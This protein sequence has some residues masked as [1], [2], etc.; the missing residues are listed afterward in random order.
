MRERRNILVTRIPPDTDDDVAGR[1]P[2][3]MRNALNTRQDAR[4]E[5]THLRAVTDSALEFE[6]V[7]FVTTP[8]EAAAVAVQEAV[9]LESRRAFSA[10][11]VRLISQAAA[12]RAG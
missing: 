9:M 7:Y 6:T 8:D 11:G 1:I 3:L 2:D 5:R 4:F 10:A 12:G